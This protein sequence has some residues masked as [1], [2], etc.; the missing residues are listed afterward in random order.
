MSPD[1]IPEVKSLI[2]RI[3]AHDA[4][5]LAARALDVESAAAVRAAAVRFIE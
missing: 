5:A 1:A 3:A 2:G 4:E